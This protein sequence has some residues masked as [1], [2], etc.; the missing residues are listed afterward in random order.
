VLLAGTSTAATVSVTSSDARTRTTFTVTVTRDTVADT[1]P[2]YGVYHHAD[3]EAGETFEAGALS[4]NYTAWVAR[5]GNDTMYDVTSAAIVRRGNA[6]GM[7]SLAPPVFVPQ[8]RLQVTPPR[9]SR[10]PLQNPTGRCRMGLPTLQTLQYPILLLSWVCFRV[11]RGFFQIERR[12]PS[13]RELIGEQ[14]TRRT[15]VAS[16]HMTRAFLNVT[17]T[18][19]IHTY[20]T[21]PPSPDG[22]ALGQLDR[23]HAHGPAAVRR[24]HSGAAAVH[25]ELARCGVRRHH[26]GWRLL[27]EHDVGAGGCAGPQR[28]AQLH[29]RCVLRAGELFTRTP[30][31]TG[32]GF[33]FFARSTRMRQRHRDVTRRA[34]E[35]RKKAN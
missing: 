11:V 27:R 32:L 30:L 26:H 18:E 12:Y 21:P 22:G 7:D 16:P 28:H 23:G 35:R 15:V 24:R 5:Y 3:G 17:Q 34:A 8:W 1:L 9:T 2:L 13:R 4:V 19:S 29:D 6:V 25:Q 14:D 20:S 33:L 10:S 31:A